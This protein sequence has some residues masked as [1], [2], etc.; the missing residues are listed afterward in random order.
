M[1]NFSRE[2]RY[3][4]LP[5]WAMS[6]L[7][8]CLVAL[9]TILVCSAQARKSPPTP[10]PAPAA[11]PTLSWVSI[12]PWGQQIFQIQADAND[13]KVLFAATN[14]GLFRST[15]AGMTWGALWLGTN[16]TYATFAQSIRVPAVMYLGIALGQTGA[17]F[18]TTDGG[19]NWA[20]IGTDDIKRPVENI[21]VDT[22]SPDTVYVVSDS[23]DGV[24]ICT[25]CVLFKSANGGR[26]WGNVAPNARSSSALPGRV[27][28][29]TVDRQRPGHL[30]VNG[31]AL[32]SQEERD[33]SNIWESTDGGLSWQHRKK[34]VVEFVGSSGYKAIAC[35]WASFLLHPS[36][37]NLIAGAADG[38]GWGGNH[39]PL[40]FLSRDGGSSWRDI[41]IVEATQFRETAAMQ[42]FAWSGTEPAT[43]FAGTSG[44]LYKSSQYGEKWQR[45][46][47]YGT[48]NIAAT[49]AGDLYAVTSAGL[50]KS[51]NGG[52]RWH[53]AGLGLPTGIGSNGC[54]LQAIAGGEIYVGCQG[55]FW[56]TADSG[57]SWT[58]FDTGAD[59]T[60]GVSAQI[61]PVRRGQDIRNLL[62]AQDKS[63]YLNLVSEGG[64]R[65]LKVQPDG[66]VINIDLRGQAPNWLDFSPT[67]PN[68]LYLTTSTG[69][70]SWK[71]PLGG[72][73][74]M[75]SDDCGFSWQSFNLA[76]W[77]RPKLAGSQMT[78][79]PLIGVAPQSSKIAY[80]VATFT[81]GRTGKKDLALERTADGGASWKD[82]FPDALVGLRYQTGQI[83]VPVAVMADPGNT[84]MVY[85]VFVNALFRASAGGTQW[86]ELPFKFGAIRSLTVSTSAPK[87]LYLANDMG[88]WSSGDGGATWTFLYPGFH[89][90]KAQKV[91]SS[92]ALTIAQGENGIFRLTDRDLNW[93]TQKWKTLEENPEADP[94]TV[95]PE[96]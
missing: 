37:S 22:D 42:S 49:Q 30:F 23:S 38:N 24:F 47:P 85:L 65:I 55:G 4:R 63:L 81:D 96:H 90:Q 2:L 83:G 57:L 61:I 46:L 36:N 33:R 74:L 11:A 68:T 6:L 31:S 43:V 62:G 20:Q 39:P 29:V 88:I 64:A 77:A 48:S 12:F 17:L 92:G 52:G 13:P 66:K 93:I 72:L 9:E 86:S 91:L 71:Y 76:R 32:F 44:S 54:S 79:V 16:L 18:R 21:Q 19:A 73:S 84:E 5:L 70:A 25:G 59:P 50:L 28:F 67:D 45:V 7:L 75:K 15:N 80:A 58:W 94:I 41:R 69:F 56:K 3:K 8:C 1:I 27:W 87:T 34:I 95:A 60:P 82:I 10:R 26:T 89:Q 51:R 35:N 53:L 40:L 78:G 14:R